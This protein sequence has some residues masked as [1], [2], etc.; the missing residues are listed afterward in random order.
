MNKTIIVK[1]DGTLV[2]QEYGDKERCPLEALQKAVGGY[3]EAVPHFDS[4]KGEIATMYCNEESKLQSNWL[5]TY[6]E[7]ATRLWA[8]AM[9]ITLPKEM[10]WK[11]PITV[12]SFIGDILVGDCI[13]VTGTRKFVYG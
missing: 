2:E 13:I 4:Y 9:G 1:T 11:E 10:S 6:N 3:I 8:E 5:D 12:G 7:E